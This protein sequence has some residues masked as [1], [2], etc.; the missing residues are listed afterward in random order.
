PAQTVTTVISNYEEVGHGAAVG[1]PAN[2][3]ELVTIDM[4]AIGEGQNSDEFS[5]GICVK[6]AGGPYHIDLTRKLRTLADE[7]NIPYQ[8]DIYPYYG[9]DGEAYWRAGGAAQVALIGPGV[10]TSHAYERTHTDS[11]LH[12]AHLIARYLL[13]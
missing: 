4:A 6:D 1:F 8:T 12:S 3:H 2:L 13:S 7:A 10:S 11:L 9:S 5:V